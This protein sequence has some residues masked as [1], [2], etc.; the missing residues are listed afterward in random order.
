MPDENNAAP[1]K[2][3]SL[4]RSMETVRYVGLLQTEGVFIAFRR[5]VG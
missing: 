3:G 4:S 5:G 2:P 1:T